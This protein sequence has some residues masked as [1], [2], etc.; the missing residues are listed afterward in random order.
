M[1]LVGFPTE[2]EA[3]DFLHAM[4]GRHRHA[5]EEGQYY[6]GKVVETEVAVLITGIGPVRAVS[7]TTEFLSK[8]RGNIFILGGFAGA[9]TEALQRGQVLI[10]RD[11]SSSQ[12][13][14]YLRLLPG[15]DIAQVHPVTELAATAEEKR[16]LGR[17]SGAQIVDMETAYLAN[18]VVQRG[19]EFMSVR[20]VSDLVGE[21]LPADVLQEGY[22]YV[23]AKTTPGRLVKF[24]FM[25]P[26]RIKAL[27]DFMAPLPGVR[28]KLTDFML[29]AVQEF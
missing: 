16:R 5:L 24:L 6:T 15:F 3:H 21:D 28:K 18:L 17:E 27:R 20:A 1:V 19:L 7:R 23:A 29:M 13:I 9:L 4:K 2:Y 22:D 14:N 12:T 8:V 11:Y 10:V 25:N 26:S